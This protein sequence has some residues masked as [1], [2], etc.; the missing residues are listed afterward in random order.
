MDVGLTG[1][2]LDEAKLGGIVKDPESKKRVASELKSAMAD[3]LGPNF[4]LQTGQIKNK[5]PKKEVTPLQEAHK[6]LK[7]LEKKNLSLRSGFVF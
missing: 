5:K 6:S 2:P 4:D 7:A 3:Q 1:H